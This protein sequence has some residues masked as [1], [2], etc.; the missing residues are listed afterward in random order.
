M[1]SRT[2]GNPETVKGVIF[3]FMLKLGIVKDPMVLSEGR[4]MWI[5]EP[6]SSRERGAHGAEPSANRLYDTTNT[7]FGHPLRGS[8]V[9]NVEFDPVRTE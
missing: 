7:P 6:R 2:V 3:V 1:R 8:T 5:R 4:K 9:L